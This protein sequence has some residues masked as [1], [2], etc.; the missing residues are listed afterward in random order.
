MN[1]IIIA[2]KDE[3]TN[4]QSPLELLLKFYDLE[5]LEEFE[6]LNMANNPYHF[7][8]CG[9]LCDCN[10]EIKNDTLFTLLTEPGRFK[11]CRKMW[12]SKK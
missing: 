9:S 6:I 7:N 3:I 1:K 11:R 10:N 12:T 2:Q 8:Y 4:A 5:F